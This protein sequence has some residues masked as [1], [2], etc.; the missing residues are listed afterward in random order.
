MTY[1]LAI[2]V[3]EGL[4]FASDSRT[5]GGVDN[6]NIYS[7]MHSFE[8]SEERAFVLLSAG[9]L[10]TTQAVINCIQRDLTNTNSKE[11]LKTFSHMFDVAHYIGGISR[12]IQTEYQSKE[13]QSS[14]S[15][16]AS[17]IL[18]GQIKG[19]PPELFLIYPEGN[20]IA[21]SQENPFLQIGEAKYGKPILD[22][23]IEP[24]LPLH[25]AGRCALVSID[26]T[27]RSNL[28]VGPPIELLYYKEASFKL[29]RHHVF[30]END[31]Y[32]HELKEAWNIGLKTVFESL[33]RFEWES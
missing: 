14:A 1:C 21:V 5:H 20:Y 3:D 4:V 18:G 17:F 31:P 6:V 16:G 9:N 26:S 13:Q 27:I 15:F 32:L 28:S 8:V 30:P 22:R 25:D 29:N 19:F 2:K 12:A 11:N 23:I 24:K 33:P 7:K 10:A